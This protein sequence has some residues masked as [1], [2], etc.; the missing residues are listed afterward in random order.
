MGSYDWKVYAWHHDG[1]DVTSVGAPGWPVDTQGAV[2]S[3]PVVGDLDGDGDLDVVIADFD[4]K[5]QTVWLNQDRS[6]YMP[7]LP[8]Y[9]VRELSAIT[10]NPM[11][12]N[13]SPR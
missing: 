6:L 4:G 8:I 11:R 7:Q 13:N 2:H 12:V 10:F 9:R 3:S 1:T 5:A